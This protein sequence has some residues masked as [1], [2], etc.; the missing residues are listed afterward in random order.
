MDTSWVLNSLSHK[1]CSQ[2]VIFTE[3]F[4]VRL[5]NLYND[6]CARSHLPNWEKTL[7]GPVSVALQRSSVS[8]S[9]ES[10]SLVRQ[11]PCHWSLVHLSNLPKWPPRKHGAC[12]LLPSGHIYIASHAFS[13]TNRTLAPHCLTFSNCSPQ[14]ISNVFK[15]IEHLL[16]VKYYI[17]YFS[18]IF[19][20]QP[21]EILH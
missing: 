8:A 1:G 5:Y 9:P 17:R 14:I 16:Y 3:C 7:P 12:H 11:L 2:E 4:T 20:L 6:P 19:A 21:S 15:F 18:S 10:P 13:Q